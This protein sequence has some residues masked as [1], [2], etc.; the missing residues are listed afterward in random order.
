M[1]AYLSNQFKP[2]QVVTYRGKEHPDLNH[3]QHLTLAK[4]DPE[5]GYWT[6][7]LPDGKFSPWVPAL[8]LML[9]KSAEVN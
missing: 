4:K 1:N 2:G 9:V 7:K 3:G 5:T 8:D 6:A